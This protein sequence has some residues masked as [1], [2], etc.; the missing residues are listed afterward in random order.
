M[1]KFLIHLSQNSAPC[2]G[3]YVGIREH[4]QG[5]W[6]LES[7]QAEA[8]GLF[9][10]CGERISMKAFCELGPEHDLNSNPVLN[11]T[12]HILHHVD[13]SF[14]SHIKY[15]EICWFYI[16]CSVRFQLCFD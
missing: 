8:K 1:T 11:S 4:H 7:L 3:H 15:I 2:S 10:S 9:Q 5:V 6:E 14:Y 16:F 12:T 13:K